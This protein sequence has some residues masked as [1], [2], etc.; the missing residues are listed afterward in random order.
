M[1]G[2]I[3]K[4]MDG[5]RSLSKVDAKIIKC[6]NRIVEGADEK[7]VRNLSA[8][9]IQD[10]GPVLRALCNMAFTTK[11]QASLVAETLIKISTGGKN[12]P[13]LCL[14]DRD[15]LLSMKAKNSSTFLVLEIIEDAICSKPTKAMCANIIEFLGCIVKGGRTVKGD[16]ES[17]Y[18][19]HPIEAIRGCIFPILQVTSWTKKDIEETRLMCGFQMLSTILCQH[20]PVLSGSPKNIDLFQWQ[21]KDAQLL[22]EKVFVHCLRLSEYGKF[23][24]KPTPC[25][26][27]LSSSLSLQVKG[28]TFIVNSLSKIERDHDSKSEFRESM[29]S[30]SL[31]YLHEWQELRNILPTLDWLTIE[32]IRPLLESIGRIQ[33]RDIITFPISLTKRPLGLELTFQESKRYENSSLP[34]EEKLLKKSRNIGV[35]KIVDIDKKTEA[36]DLGL[37]RG[38][39]IVSINDSEATFANLSTALKSKVDPVKLSVELPILSSWKD[40]LETLV[41]RLPAFLPSPIEGWMCAVGLLRNTLLCASLSYEHCARVPW[42]YQNLYRLVEVEELKDVIRVR[43]S[44]DTSLREATALFPGDVEDWYEATVGSI[45]FCKQNLTVKSMEMCFTDYEDQEEC[46]KISLDPCKVILGNPW[47]L[48]FCSFIGAQP[49]NNGEELQRYVLLQSSRALVWIFQAELHV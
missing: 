5:D 1:N 40:V 41:S 14:K 19:L 13:L 2:D 30:D 11:G 6:L 35:L 42:C 47:I 4:K 20:L 32:R 12:F 24:G 48:T 45:D 15:L 25:L 22:L 37:C 34:E 28:Y 18:G 9:A 46:A 17:R 33:G 29:L 27:E 31:L 36:N 49:G 39:K 3:L 43:I 7:D 10:P 21:T 23:E 44:G 26:D 16:W 8:I 38:C